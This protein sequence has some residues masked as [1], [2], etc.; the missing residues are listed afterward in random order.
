MDT[1]PVCY[2][3]QLSFIV[4]LPR[5][6]LPVFFVYETWF[7]DAL[8]KEVIWRPCHDDRLLSIPDEKSKELY[9][10]PIG[11]IYWIVSAFYSPFTMGFM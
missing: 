4:I 1:M 8:T 7:G 5:Y 6:V 9:S 2:S 11:E 3:D 10:C